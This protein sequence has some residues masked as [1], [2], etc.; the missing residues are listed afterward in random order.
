MIICLFVCCFCLL[1][2]SFV[3]NVVIIS[4]LSIHNW[5]LGFLQRLSLHH[6]TTFIITSLCVWK[7]SIE[8]VIR[9]DIWNKQHYFY[10]DSFGA[11]IYTNSFWAGYLKV[12]VRWPLFYYI[13]HNWKCLSIM[14]IFL[15]PIR[16]VWRYQRGYQNPN[17]EEWP[18]EKG[19]KDISGS[20]R[21]NPQYCHFKLY[22]G[23]LS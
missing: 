14:F 3:A 9:V 21:H 4:E 15:Y 16:K 12:I 11:R 5:P 20:H 13:K 18:I 6:R 2:V 1:L 23:C 19:Q 8:M 17:F 22:L 7:D 10:N